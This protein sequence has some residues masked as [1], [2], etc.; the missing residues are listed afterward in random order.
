MRRKVVAL[1]GFGTGVAIGTALYRR[2][3]GRHRERVDLYFD[4]GS[5]VSLT[6][7]SP[8]AAGL[9]PVAHEILATARRPR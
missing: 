9:L 3:A 1:I 7:G 2:G 6:D 5:M 4:D 8:G